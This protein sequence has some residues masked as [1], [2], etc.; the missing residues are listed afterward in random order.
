MHQNKH[1]SGRRSSSASETSL[2]GNHTPVLLQEVLSLLDPH[3]G[4]AYL[5]LT[6]GYGG[7]A[8]EILA[9][10]NA[11]KKATLV[12][13]DENAMRYLE[14][15]IDASVTRL[16][17]DFESAAAR[18]KE[19]GETF[20][21]VFADIGVSSPHLNDASRGF[22]IRGEGPLDMRMDK[23]QSLTAA[24]IVNTYDKDSLTRVLRQYG[25]EPKA[26]RVAG[27]IIDARPL[28]TTTQLADIVKR[29]W[30]GRSKVHPATR[31]F[32]ALRIEV[33]D[34][35]GMLERAL[36]LWV[37]LLNPGG[38]LG[39]ISFHS[40]EDR[41]VKQFFA[42]RA[43]H[44]FDATLRTLNKKPLIASKSEIVSNPRSRSAKLRGVV[45][46]KR[47]G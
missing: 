22:S 1:K 2:P 24:D 38:R 21:I 46:I 19:Q 12:D 41:I 29:S 6:A 32:Q 45:K 47:K 17:A 36:P 18:L 27:A 8:R 15:N 13:R 34:E 33:N 43:G 44:R 35:L 16:H 37:D 5:D 9:L 26:A 4:E 39:V 25:E 14:K 28:S 31:T 30:R 40:L 42:E 11:P 20:D 7:H 3:A 23:R 10:T